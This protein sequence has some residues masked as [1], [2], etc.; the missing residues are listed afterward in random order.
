MGKAR[1]KDDLNT[2]GRMDQSSGWMKEMQDSLGKWGGAL[3]DEFCL[4]C[5]KFQ[6]SLSQQEGTYWE[7][8]ACMM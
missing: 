5:V 3:N 4:G 2:P 7:C 1:E 6:V 8:G